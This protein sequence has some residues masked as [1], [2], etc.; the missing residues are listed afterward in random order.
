MQL[1]NYKIGHNNFASLLHTFF[2]AT[3]TKLSRFNT[4][5][6]VLGTLQHVKFNFK[7]AE[8]HYSVADM[9]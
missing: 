3:E 2:W 6:F 4:E 9:K 7:V 1:F 5:S 8:S